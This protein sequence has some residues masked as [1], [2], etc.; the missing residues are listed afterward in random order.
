MVKLNLDYPY[1]DEE[2][3]PLKVPEE[4]RSLETD[5]RTVSIYELAMRYVAKEIVLEPDFQRH[6]A[7]DATRA[8]R[9]I[10]SLLLGLPSPPIF[11]SEEQSGQWTVIDG[12]QRLETIFR[13]IRPALGNLANNTG[14]SSGQFTGGSPLRLRSLEV[15]PELNGRDFR[16][17]PHHD[18]PRL[19][20]TKLTL[21]SLPKTAHPDLKYVLFARLNLG[22]MTLNNQELRN[23]IYRGSYNRLI[24][25]IA[26]GSDFLNLWNRGTPDKRMR[27][28]ERVLRFFA[29]LHR[30]DRYRTP[31]RAFLNDEMVEFRE[32]DKEDERRFVSEVE[33]ATEW[34]RRVFGTDAFYPFRVGNADNPPG[35]WVRRRYDILY[36]IEMV[37]FAEFGHSLNEVWSKLDSHERELFRLAL[38]RRLISVMTDDRFSVTLSE[39]TT[40]PEVV[41]NRFG[42]W[43]QT[44]ESALRNPKLACNE[45]SEIIERLR[46]TS[47]CSVC[48]QQMTYDDATWPPAAGH[49]SLAHRYCAQAN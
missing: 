23:C 42:M 8:S 49:Q 12:H 38:R 10:E 31:F 13:Y 48:P 44:I 15:M 34:L 45:A 41:R 39:G 36:E 32:I 11:V 37:G 27:D 4:F 17:L 33:T 26:E 9:F 21:I 19:M 16:S 5:E 20:D 30:R 28:R 22:S 40:R 47:I 6:Y 35:R 25:R 46:D 43:N 14:A 3:S 18:I 1:D 29:L 24:A 7:W 2:Y